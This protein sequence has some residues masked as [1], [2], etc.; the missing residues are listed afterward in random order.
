MSNL[1][2][3]SVKQEIVKAYI[4]LDNPEY[5]FLARGKSERPYQDLVDELLQRFFVKD[6][7]NVNQDV[8]FVYLLCNVV[9]ETQARWMLQLSLVARYGVLFSLTEKG[10]ELLCSGEYGSEQIAHLMAKWRVPILTSEVLKTRI[11][12]KLFY[13]EPENVCIYQALFSDVDLLPW[14]SRKI[15]VPED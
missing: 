10:P 8:S 5:A 1:T 3:E 12:L 7:T 11:P 14:E 4:S 15:L 13:T 9:A 2:V 6:S